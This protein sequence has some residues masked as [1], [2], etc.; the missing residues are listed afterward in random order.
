MFDRGCGA[1]VPANV[2]ISVLPSYVPLSN[3]AGNALVI[4][5]NRAASSWH[6]IDVVWTS[7]NSVRI[8]YPRN[9]RV[10]KHEGRVGS[11]DVA[12]VARESG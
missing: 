7:N 12:Y 8:T 5:T 1:T 10:F 6:D 3:E 11:V 4:D 9:A 2:Q